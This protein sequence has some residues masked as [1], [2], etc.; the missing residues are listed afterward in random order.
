MTTAIQA[1]EAENKTLRGDVARLQTQVQSINNDLLVVQSRVEN[2]PT[3]PQVAGAPAP[4]AKPV[5][6]APKKMYRQESFLGDD[7]HFTDDE[8]VNPNSMKFTNRD[9]SNMPLQVLPGTTSGKNTAALPQANKSKSGN[10]SETTLV[11]DT[12]KAD[13]SKSEAK[14][15]I[16]DPAIVVSYNRAYKTFTDQNYK[17]TIRLMGEFLA[18]YPSHEYSDNATFW[19]GESY[20]QL[21]NFD[22][23]YVEFEKVITKYPNGNKVPDAML[24]S[25]ICMLKLSKPEKA[26]SSFDQ[27]IKKYPES[28]AAKKAKASRGDL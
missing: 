20:Y 27:L 8:P 14:P 3:M 15:N 24:R 4:A 17:E 1:L 9:L 12:S 21:K 5:V 6:E 10:F 26:K 28:V 13:T 19:T 11:A 7:I 18:Q 22:Q 23:A 25:G 2:H 16:E